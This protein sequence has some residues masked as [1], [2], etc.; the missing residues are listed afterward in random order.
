MGAVNRLPTS[1]LLGVSCKPKRILSNFEGCSCN[2]VVYP[3][4]FSEELEAGTGVLF[5]NPLDLTSTGKYF[6][7]RSYTL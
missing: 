3:S 6:S 4:R 5:L 7:S 2:I 1:K